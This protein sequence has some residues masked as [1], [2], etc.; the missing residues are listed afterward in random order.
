MKGFF[1]KAALVFTILFGVATFIFS[2]VIFLSFKDEE[3][4]Y[5]EEFDI[6][7][8]GEGGRIATEIYASLGE[9]A[10]ETTT[11][12][13]NGRVTSTS[14]DYYYVVPAWDKD[15][16][17]YYICVKVDKDDRSTYEKIT[18]ETWDYLYGH[19][20]YYGDTTIDFEGTIEELD[21]ELYDYMLEWFREGEMFENETD[22]RNHVLQLC[23]EPLDFDSAGIFIAIV[24]VLLVL[25]V[26]FWILFFV[27]G[28]NRTSNAY[29]GNA[30]NGMNN[31]INFDGIPTNTNMPQYNA[32]PYNT[33]YNNN[34]Y[35]NDPYN[36]Y[37]NNSSQNTQNNQFNGF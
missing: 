17:T 31:G 25:A 37:N 24:I 8:H 7:E 23:L 14:T 1:L 5:G 6:I 19:T 12:K 16:E 9:C 30:M 4:L 22:L 10:S 36:T 3:D 29:A 33:Q 35:N 20:D 28:K 27:K 18:N 32:D 15:E 11:T 2:D 21:D 26:L 34:T 13:K